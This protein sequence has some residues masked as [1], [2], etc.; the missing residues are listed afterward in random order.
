MKAFKSNIETTTTNQIK[1]KYLINKVG[2][3]TQFHQ[4]AIFSSL[5][6]KLITL[7]F[8]SSKQILVTT[9]YLFLKNNDKLG[10]KPPSTLSSFLGL[11][12]SQNEPLS[13]LKYA[14]LI[15]FFL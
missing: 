4:E 10:K 5:V 8:S 7:P 3:I 6:E 11:Y 12:N 13:F 9:I 1:I 15:I 14:Q 2:N